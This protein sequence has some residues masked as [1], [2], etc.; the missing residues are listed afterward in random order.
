MTTG[1][2]TRPDVST[3]AVETVVPQ[4]TLSTPPYF[5]IGVWQPSSEDFVRWKRRGINT[6]VEIPQGYNVNH[7]SSEATVNEL[8]QMRAP[9][10][11]FTDQAGLSRDALTVGL[12][13]WLHGDEPDSSK[14]DPN[15]LQ[16]AYSTMKTVAPKLPV[17]VM[18]SNN[19]VMSW[20]N[21]QAPAIYQHYIKAA[22]WL[23][24]DIYP[25]AGWSA[26][27]SLEIVTHVL[28]VMNQWSNKPK[29]GCIGL[30]N[31]FNN[32]AVDR[33]YATAAEINAQ[34][35]LAVTAGLRGIVYC[36]D[37]NNQGVSYDLV[38]ADVINAM[39]QANCAVARWA[40]GYHKAIYQPLDSGNPSV[41][42]ACWSTSSG[43]F[44]AA[45]NWTTLPQQALGGCFGPLEVKTQEVVNHPAD[46]PA[47]LSADDPMTRL[48]AA[49]ASIRRLIQM[50]GRLDMQ[51]NRV[52]VPAM[53]NAKLLP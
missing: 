43:T 5:P 23:G 45:V 24:N 29:I 18:F 41:R 19:Y 46:N 17:A 40:S 21:G 53:K 42:A 3:L 26:S 6:V 9:L 15:T 8:W 36:N 51:V 22:D 13:A 27:S 44:K 11:E 28:S 34:V 1:S 10:A 48:L 7:W 31:Q 12:L 52:M 30:G 35:W 37:T 49:E 38:P 16:L 25:L 47:P 2:A 33:R 50:N 39:E 20:P 4:I 32:W 14:I